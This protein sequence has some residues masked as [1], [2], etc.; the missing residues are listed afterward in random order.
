MLLLWFLVFIGI[1]SLV[2]MVDFYEPSDD[3]YFFSDFL[4]R[5]LRDFEGNIDFLDMGT[6]SGVLS[7]TV[8]EFVRSLVRIV[9]W[10]LIKILNLLVL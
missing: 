1:S 10:L 6:G 2:K 8:S 3:S 9:F 5:Y 7:E 4:D